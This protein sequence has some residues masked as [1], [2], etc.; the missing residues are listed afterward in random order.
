MANYN[1]IRAQ[2]GDA[3]RSISD[4]I[5]VHDDFPKSVVPPAAVIKPQIPTV[6]YLQAFGSGFAEWRFLIL[7]I[8]G[9]ASEAS[10]QRMLG[11]LISPE[12]TLISTLH[13]MELG[14][15]YVTVTNGAVSETKIGD[16]SYC[17]ARLSVTVR[18]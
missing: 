4:D 2:L 15:G 12:S 18:A 1:T 5:N 6:N 9:Q 3:L 17:Y 14:T 10:A 11:D 8:V 16:T 7:L 13:G